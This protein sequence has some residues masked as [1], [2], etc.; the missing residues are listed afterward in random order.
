MNSRYIGAVILTPIV[1]FLI[2][3]GSL[4]QYGLLAISLIGL[5]EF[6][7]V[8]GKR[9]INTFRYVGYI[10]TIFYYVFLYKM[11]F[12]LIAFMLFLLVMLLLCIPSINLN[13]NY[14]DLSV[15]I[16]GII[17][18]SVFFSFITLVN[19]KVNGN[20]LVWLIFISSWASDTAAYYSGKFFG[21]H[22]LCPKVS[23]KKTIEGSIG[24][25]CGSVLGCS[26]L[27]AVLQRYNVNIPLVHFVA[28][29]IIS[30]V[31][32]Q[33][34]DLAASSIKRHSEVKDYG[35]LIPGHGG[36]L[37]R[38]DSILFSAVVVFYYLTFILGI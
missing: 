23:P 35:N 9:G 38:F 15:T 30:G 27:W 20:Y 12:S 34:G 8:A 1:V 14:M 5:N 6:Y 33:F 4:L 3:G 25:L 26:I 19:T 7:N 18:V 16:L 21:K 36:V 31:F 32:S 29:G 24:G 37:D 22:K 10:F 2:M 17:Y 13:Y 11:N 28:I